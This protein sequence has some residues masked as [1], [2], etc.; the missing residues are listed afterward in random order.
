MLE[1]TRLPVIPSRTVRIRPAVRRAARPGRGFG[2]VSGTLAK[3][4]A[5]RHGRAGGDGR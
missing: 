1:H 5:R 4:A 2:R 3:P